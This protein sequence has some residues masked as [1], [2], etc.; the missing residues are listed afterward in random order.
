M[1]R[2]I[3]S[4]SKNGE[5]VVKEPSKV[6][7]LIKNIKAKHLIIAWDVI[8][9]CLLITFIILLAVRFWPSKTEVR[10]ANSIEN[11]VIEYTTSL[12][13]GEDALIQE[14]LVD[15]LADI[16]ITDVQQ[17]FV[18]AYNPDVENCKDYWEYDYENNKFIYEDEKKEIKKTTNLY[19]TNSKIV[20]DLID[21]I[22]STKGNENVWNTRLYI[23]DMTKATNRVEITDIGGESVNIDLSI[24]GISQALYFVKLRDGNISSNNIAGN[25]KNAKLTPYISNI[26]ASL[27]K[28]TYYIHTNANDYTE[29][30]EYNLSYGD[31]LPICKDYYNTD[32]VKAYYNEDNGY[33]AIYSWFKTTDSSFNPESSANEAF[34]PNNDSNKKV[35]YQ[36]VNGNIVTEFHFYGVKR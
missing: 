35:Q 26:Q 33:K 24:E 1:A 8:A 18:Y 32:V 3:K 12:K 10:E 25:I 21:R 11:K 4:S 16:N 14:V 9:S 19:E 36:N 27:Y 28:Y 29:C 15:E 22:T 2:I 13:D 31:Y 6:T 20:I 30:D 23:I 7:K 17:C 5:V 34:E